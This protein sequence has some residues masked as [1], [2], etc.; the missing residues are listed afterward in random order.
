MI[1]KK[2][3]VKILIDFLIIF[4]LLIIVFYYLVKNDISNH[5][6]I[7]QSKSNCFVGKD[8]ILH[9]I[10]GF[11][12]I[13]IENYICKYIYEIDRSIN[14][15]PKTLCTPNMSPDNGWECKIIK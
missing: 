1:D 8:L 7:Q 14:C 5:E 12:K 9:K 13:K 6:C 4:V 15:P 3:L 10:F 2:L 11:K